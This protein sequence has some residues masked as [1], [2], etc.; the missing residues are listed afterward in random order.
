MVNP[1]TDKGSVRTFLSTVNDQDLIWHRDRED[2]TIT[3]LEGSGWSFQFD[4]QM[5]I[6]LI[7]GNVIKIPAMKYHRILKKDTATD[8]KLQIDRN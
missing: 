3:V 7:E 2:R 5:P 6:E 1:Y 8:L 4:D